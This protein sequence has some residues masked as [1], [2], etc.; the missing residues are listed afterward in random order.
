MRSSFAGVVLGLLASLGAMR[1]MR[2]QI[3]D[4]P[5]L[6]PVATA[7]ATLILLA[8]AW[9]ASAVPARRAGRVDPAALLRDD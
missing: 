7:A 3:S 6:D 1:L 5:A 8:A 2:A 4:V 9:L